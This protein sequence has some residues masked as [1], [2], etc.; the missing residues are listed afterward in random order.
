MIKSGSTLFFLPGLMTVVVTFGPM[1]LNLWNPR[2][3][4]NYK[5]SLF[6]YVL[7]NNCIVWES[8]SSVQCF[9]N[10]AVSSNKSF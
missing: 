10:F 2:D 5:P 6:Q 8:F 9:E 4:G 7:K 3:K 1:R